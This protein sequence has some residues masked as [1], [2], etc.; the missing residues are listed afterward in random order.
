MSFNLKKNTKMVNIDRHAVS[1]SSL[2]SSLQLKSNKDVY[3]NVTDVNL[4]EEL[5]T[6]H[7]NMEY[8]R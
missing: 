4:D 6:L 2:L 8:L 5:K 3:L 7:S 1:A